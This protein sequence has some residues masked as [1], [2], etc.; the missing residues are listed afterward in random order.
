MNFSTSSKSKS[1]TEVSTHSSLPSTQP[2][3]LEVQIPTP[4]KPQV[5]IKQVFNKVLNMLTLHLH[6]HLNQV[7]CFVTFH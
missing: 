6:L 2:P 5:Y 1:K 3:R 7:I 4:I